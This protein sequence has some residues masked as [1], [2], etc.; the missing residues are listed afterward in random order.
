MLIR[1]HKALYLSPMRYNPNTEDIQVSAKVV[2]DLMADERVVVAAGNKLTLLS[3]AHTKLIGDKCV[4]AFTTQQEV[5]DTLSETLPTTLYVTETLEQ[6]DGL[7]LVREV[8]KKSGE[9]KVLVFLER[10]HPGVIKDAID[11][12]ADGILLVDEMGHGAFG[13]AVLAISRGGTYFPSGVFDAIK[14][15]SSGSERLQLLSLLTEREVEVL[16]LVCSGKSNAEIAEA[17]VISSTTVKS[18]MSSLLSKM[19]VSDRTQLVVLAL[20]NNL[21]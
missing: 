10:S 17:C 11:S 13:D 15:E 21:V 19:Q 5:L 18:H 6:G 16:D 14:E 7:S 4:G 12:G 3:M 2:R 9:I 20:R 1:I 8:K